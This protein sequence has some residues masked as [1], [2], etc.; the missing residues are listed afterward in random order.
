LEGTERKIA[1]ARKLHADP[2]AGK[3]RAL[4]EWGISYAI[5]GG[6][7][8]LACGVPRLISK[9]DDLNKTPA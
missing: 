2:A 5:M 7:A 1:L 9:F 4:E 8:G 3:D 6:Q